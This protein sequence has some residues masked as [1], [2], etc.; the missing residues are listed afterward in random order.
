MGLMISEGFSNLKGFSG[1]ICFRESFVPAERGYLMA[2]TESRHCKVESSSSPTCDP[3]C[4]KTEPRAGPP[5]GGEGPQRW[6]LIKAN[7]K[8]ILGPRCLWAGTMPRQGDRGVTSAASHGVTL[9]SHPV[10]APLE[11]LWDL[12]LDNRGLKKA[13]KHGAVSGCITPNP[14]GNALVRGI[15]ELLQL[16]RIHRD[17]R[18]QREQHPCSSSTHRARGGPSHLISGSSEDSQELAALGSLNFPGKGDLQSCRDQPVIRAVPERCCPTLSA[19]SVFSR[20]LLPGAAARVPRRCPRRRRWLCLQLPPAISAGLGFLQPR[21]SAHSCP[22]GSRRSSPSAAAGPEPPSRS[23]ADGA[24]P[25]SAGSGAGIAEGDAAAA[26][27]GL[28]SH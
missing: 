18:V 27:H 4:C 24:A 22:G 2:Q 26:Q 7:K 14:T 20:S 25:G 16:E 15:A 1:S 6:D 21:D 5:K 12:P 3:N 9:D 13:R 19:G 17:H 8:G 28:R 10:P 11:Q 23:Q